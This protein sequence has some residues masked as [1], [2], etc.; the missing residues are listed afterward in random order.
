MS[1]RI[2]VKLDVQSFGQSQIV[3]EAQSCK[4]A[5]AN[6]KGRLVGPFGHQIDPSG[7]DREAP[8]QRKHLVEIRRLG[9][10]ELEERSRLGRPPGQPFGD[11]RQFGRVARM[12]QLGADVVLATSGRAPGRRDGNVGL[13]LDLDP[14][15]SASV[16]A[17]AALR[18]GSPPVT[19]GAA[20]P[21]RNAAAVPL[22]AGPP[23][24]LPVVGDTRSMRPVVSHNRQV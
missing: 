14:R 23:G 3:S 11:Q 22:R 16:R 1:S 12:G 6:G 19:T 10:H 24:G 20:S 9:D 17:R 13:D 4:P 5:L 8:G 18:S 7:R 2:T 21:R 15:S